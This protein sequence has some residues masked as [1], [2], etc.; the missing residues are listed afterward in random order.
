MNM[1]YKS[2]HYGSASLRLSHRA[3][4]LI[5]IL[6][7]VSI[8]AILI[9]ILIPALAAAK[10]ESE[11]VACLANQRTIAQSLVMFAHQHNGYMVKGQNNGYG[12]NANANPTFSDGAYY[13]SPQIWSYGAI[14]APADSTATG[15]GSN[16]DQVLISDKFITPGVLRD[17]AD[18]TGNVRYPAAAPPAGNTNPINPALN[19]PA[20]YRLNSSNQP[21]DPTNPNGATYYSPAYNAYA[22]VSIA[23]PQNAIVVSDGGFGTAGTTNYQQIP[24]VATWAAGATASNADEAISGTPSSGTS[25]VNN[26]NPIIHSGK[27]NVA[28]LDGH[29]QTMAWGDTWQLIGSQ[30][31][32]GYTGLQTAWRQNFSPNYGGQTET[33]NGVSGQE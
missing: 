28:F 1:A 7:V 21:G 3:F 5:E 25:G 29:C 18:T 6:V 15:T 11:T 10:A 4:T 22:L 2:T 20:S 27:M 16:W 17:P 8:I 12:A 9:A 24:D 26:V 19:V 33:I 30:T 32:T 13:G 14:T 31:V 23:N